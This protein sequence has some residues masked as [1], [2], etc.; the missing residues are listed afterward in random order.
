MA[1]IGR[2]L[3]LR[4]PLVGPQLAVHFASGEMGVALDASGRQRWPFPNLTFA[5]PTRE[6]SR[7]ETGA[8]SQGCSTPDRVLAF[9]SAPHAV[10][11][12]RTVL[13]AARTNLLQRACYVTCNRN[14]TS[15]TE[16]VW[17]YCL[18]RARKKVSPRQQDGRANG[19]VGD[20]KPSK[21]VLNFS[22]RVPMCAAIG[23]GSS[24]TALLS[25]QHAMSVEKANHEPPPCNAK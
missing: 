21:K 11:T 3:R 17:R 6:F 16:A 4:T 24:I 12:R 15:V 1:S 10:C 2:D 8:V 5:G 25:E 23:A 7:W 20:G 13:P 18:Q 9:T 22:D 14:E 19:G